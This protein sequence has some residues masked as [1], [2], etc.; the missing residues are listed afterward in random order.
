M[1]KMFQKRG[2]FLEKRVFSK[3]RL[4]FEEKLISRAVEWLSVDRGF[5][6]RLFV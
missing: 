1:Q 6:V 2:S 5:S 3:I 4:I